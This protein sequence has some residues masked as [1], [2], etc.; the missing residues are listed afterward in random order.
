MSQRQRPHSPKPDASRQ[1]R[2]PHEHS[3]PDDS[4]QGETNLIVALLLNVGITI[5]QVVGGLL[6]SSL[7][8]LAD[9]AHNGSDAA[10]LGISYWARR[11]ARRPADRRHTFGYER[12]KLI[13]AMINLTVLFVIGLFL[14]YAAGRRF[15]RPSEVGSLTMLIV[16]GIAFVEDAISTW[17]LYQNAGT[18]QNIRAAFIHLFADTLATVGVIVG[19]LLIRFYGVFW[20]DPALTLA[21]AVYVLIHSYVELRETIALLME[22]APPDFN[23]EGMIRALKDIEGVQDLHHVH[24]WRLDEKRLAM[25]AHLVVQGTDTLETAAAMK[26]QAKHLLQRNFEIDHATLE[27]DAG[28]EPQHQDTTFPHE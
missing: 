15:L 10:S 27:L 21:I 8:L 9:A 3:E 5:A 4:E 2:S 17:L 23:Y 12:A 28:P 26:R 19:A 24:V 6:S 13:G 1:E 16:G 20:V 11:I 7:S 22:S 18:S 14:L 25:E